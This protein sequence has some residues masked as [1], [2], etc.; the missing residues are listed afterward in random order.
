MSRKDERKKKDAGKRQ[1]ILTYVCAA[2]IALVVLLSAYIAF[3]LRE[4]QR[5]QE[6][7]EAYRELYYASPQAQ[8]ETP[9]SPSPTPLPT[10]TRAAPF[11]R[12]KWWC[13]TARWTKTASP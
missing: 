7:G 1:R 2:L 5:A 13:S 4:S 3:S 12:W 8:T 9:A 11:R 6:Q 10:A